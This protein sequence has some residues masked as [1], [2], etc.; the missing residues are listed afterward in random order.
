MATKQIIYRKASISVIF[1]W[2]WSWTK[3]NLG[4]LQTSSITICTAYVCCNAINGD[5]SNGFG[6]ICTLYRQIVFGYCVD[7]SGLVSS[8]PP[9]DFTYKVNL[10]KIA[11]IRKNEQQ[12]KYNQTPLIPLNT[13]PTPSTRIINIYTIILFITYILY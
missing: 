1:T 3:E 10:T 11:Y 2:W 6:V 13:L 9:Q 8:L 12:N 4:C 7:I 5:I